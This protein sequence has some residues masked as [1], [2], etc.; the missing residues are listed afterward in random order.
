MSL[1]LPAKPENLGTDLV[2]EGVD[3]RAWIWINGRYAGA[4][5]PAAASPERRFAAD[6]GD[7]LVWEAEN[8]ITVRVQNQSGKGGILKPVTLEIVK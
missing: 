6:A 4:Y 5:D 2:F 1:T 8:Q 7:F 3:E